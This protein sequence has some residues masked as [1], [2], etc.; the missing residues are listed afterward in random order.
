MNTQEFKQKLADA[1]DNNLPIIE[2][3]NTLLAE[4]ES[5][6]D[7]DF[8]LLYQLCATH[9]KVAESAENDQGMTPIKNSQF[10]RDSVDWL[11]EHLYWIDEASAVDK[12]FHTL[13]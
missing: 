9:Y 5:E 13:S 8:N 4:L 7:K 12:R 2:K 11:I 1:F 6:E 10:W 3:V